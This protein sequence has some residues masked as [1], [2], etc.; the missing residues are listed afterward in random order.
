MLRTSA[1]N[2]E[3]FTQQRRV[4]CALMAAD[5]G[6]A[7]VR[8]SR[9]VRIDGGGSSCSASRLPDDAARWRGECRRADR[10]ARERRDDRRRRR[11]GGR[12]PRRARSARPRAASAPD[13]A[14]LDAADH[15][16]SA[17]AAE[18][19]RGARAAAPPSL[20][21]CRCR[22][23]GAARSGAGRDT[24]RT[25]R[26]RRCGARPRTARVARRRGGL[27]R[28]R[29]RPA[30]WWPRRRRRSGRRRQRRPRGGRGGSAAGVSASSTGAGMTARERGGCDIRG[31]TVR[32]CTSTS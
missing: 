28:P 5:G 7:Y 13:P 14:E 32:R 3:R 12:E 4:C 24:Q 11:V 26:P 23:D 8:D 15:S 30:R 16:A 31:A 17:R 6:G 20:G 10:A 27:G 21:G 1:R 19:R 18:A 22:A 9:A 2:S 25:M 29:R